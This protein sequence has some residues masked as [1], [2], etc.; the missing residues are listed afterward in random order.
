[1]RVRV[2]LNI[3]SFRLRHFGL[4]HHILFATSTHTS[5]LIEHMIDQG[6]KIRLSHTLMFAKK[7]ST[8][9][10][11]SFL[12]SYNCYWTKHSLKLPE[13][14]LIVNTSITYVLVGKYCLELEYLVLNKLAKRISYNDCRKYFFFQQLS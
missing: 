13:G 7:I 5:I 9:S 2:I 3:V 6:R 14:I 10:S 4:H 12:I 1:M 11:N 8:T